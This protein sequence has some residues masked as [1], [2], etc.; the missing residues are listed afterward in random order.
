MEL[1]RPQRFWRESD[2]FAQ[3]SLRLLCP[4]SMP[5][6]LCWHLSSS[7]FFW[8]LC[9][10]KGPDRPVENDEFS[11]RSQMW[12]LTEF[13]EVVEM[14]YVAKALWYNKHWTYSISDKHTSLTD[15]GS[16]VQ[17]KD[18]WQILYVHFVLIKIDKLLSPFLRRHS[19]ML[20]KT[21]IIRYSLYPSMTHQN[22]YF[23]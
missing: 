2:L 5:V 18:W 4:Q 19:S 17:S 3:G 21:A 10:S 16:S 13:G 6:Q 14:N 7:F 15:K 23:T 11:C 22:R 12:L 20:P 8:G 1:D 9:R